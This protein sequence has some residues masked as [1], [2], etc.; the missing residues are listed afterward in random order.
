MAESNLAIITPATPLP[1]Q[2]Q[3][4]AWWDDYGMLPNIRRHSQV[5]CQ[6]ALLVTDWLAEGGSRLNREAVEAGALLH[7]IAKTPCLGTDKLHAVEGRDHHARPWL[8]G[9]GLFSQ[10]SCLFTR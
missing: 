7:D 2:E 9:N 5:V 10:K 8:P 3:I 4:L 1:S 6:V